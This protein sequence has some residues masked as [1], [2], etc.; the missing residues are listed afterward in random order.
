M[1]VGIV[2]YGK[3]GRNI[4]SLLS[5]TPMEIVV[6]GRDAEAMGRE[7]QRLEKRLRRAAGGG[8]MAA[9]DLERR[10][11]AQRFTT[12]WA[13]LRDC[14]LV[15]ETIKEDF[16][17]KIAVLQ[18]AEAAISRTAVLTSNTSSLSLTTMAERLRQPERF[19]GFH[20]FHPVRLT[21]VVEIIVAACTA[22]HVVDTLKTVAREIGRTPL[23]V[24]DLPGSC[25]NV[26]LTWQTCE[27][28]YILEQGLA[29]PSRI[30]EI[31]VRFAR[32]GPCEAMDTIGIPFFTDVLVNTIDAFAAE[33]EVPALCRAL[34]RDGHSGK[35]AGRG[36]YLYQG[37]T[38][39]DGARE[40]YANPAQTHTPRGVRSDEAAL[41]ERLLF[42]IYF[43][44]LK[45]AQRD[46][47]SLDDLCLGISDLI[48]LKLDPMAEMRGLGSHGLREVFG[49]LHDELGPRYDAKPLDSILTTLDRR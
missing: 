45:V 17:T 42:P 41:Y 7:G 38:P 31:A 1:K 35:Y 12:A 23:V 16:E 14:D 3:M 25:I 49:R 21:S 44:S 11:A 36:I 6:L 37:D 20:F 27:A 32:F 48:G 30:D 22:P 9:D 46:L 43:A 26:P 33:L 18:Q 4:F 15:I 29:L 39:T 24:K 19:C 2:G 47:A 28:L 13:D 10:L 40:T 5:E 8:V 34:I